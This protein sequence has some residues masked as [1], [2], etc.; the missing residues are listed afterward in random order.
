MQTAILTLRKASFFVVKMVCVI[1]CT[2]IDLLTIPPGFD[3]GVELHSQK[4]KEGKEPT[5]DQQ[6]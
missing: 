3:E 1:A 5:I 4:L 6:G 2:S